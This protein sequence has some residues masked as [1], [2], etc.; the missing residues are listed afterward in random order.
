MLSD[1]TKHLFGLE[2][3]EVAERSFRREFH[4][5]AQVYRPGSD[6]E[7]AAATAL[8][9]AEEVKALSS[10]QEVRVKAAF[11]NSPEI[12]G[13]LARLSTTAQEILGQIEALI[14]FPRPSGETALGS[15]VQVTFAAGE[16]KTS[17]AIPE[18][19]LFRT[20]DGAFV[21]TVS[22]DHM[23]RTLIKVG[24][25]SDGFIEVKDGL[26]AGDHIITKGVDQ[27][28]MVEL[29]AIKGGTPCCPVPKK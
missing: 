9:N 12:I 16:P 4:T 29:S 26:Y 10:G 15:F 20:A 7:P 21:Y 25:K 27:L 17:L 23:M 11:G 3:A 28:W 18:S 2:I 8:I 1:Q 19:A 6:H 22:G 5:T 24:A 13:K 14:E